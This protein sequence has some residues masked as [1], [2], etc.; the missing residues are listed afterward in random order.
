MGKPT[1]EACTA[2]TQISCLHEE[3]L[4]P[5]VVVE[6]PVKTLITLQVFWLGSVF[7][8]HIAVS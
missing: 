7:P 4:G 6:S 5:W 8:L 2:R 1:N 3:T